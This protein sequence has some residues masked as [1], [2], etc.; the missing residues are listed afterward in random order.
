MS[1]L[2]LVSAATVLA[3]VFVAAWLLAPLPE[4]GRNLSLS[5]LLGAAFGIVLQRSRF[6][7]YCIARD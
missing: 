2:R 1:T 7:F 3:A 6:C 4:G 5:V